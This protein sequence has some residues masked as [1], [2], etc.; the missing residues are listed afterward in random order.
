MTTVEHPEN[1]GDRLVLLEV[2]VAYLVERQDEVEKLA[3]ATQSLTDA[4]LS[5]E[6]ALRTVGEVKQRQEQ[7]ARTV[8]HV[9]HRVPSRGRLALLILCI[10]VLAAGVAYG[11]WD[12]VQIHQQIKH[13][14]DCQREAVCLP[15][16]ATTGG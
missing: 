11:T 16:P 10:L 2:A 15:H 13:L 14:E 8:R 1:V 5:V 7:L 6:A 12:R 9:A 3:A 4:T